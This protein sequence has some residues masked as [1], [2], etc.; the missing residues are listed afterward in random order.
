MVELTLPK[1]AHWSLGRQ[2]GPLM[3]ANAM[4][5]HVTFLTALISAAGGLVL[6]PSSLAT[7]YCTGPGVPVGCVG[8][9]LVRAT[10]PG[11]G[12]PGLGV[13]PGVGVT[14]GVGA[15]ARG[16]G[17]SPAAGPGAGPNAGGPV[18]RLGRR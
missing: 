8:R 7:P 12:A 2:N 4:E 5:R 1:I 14:P 15:G 13:S 9:P 11:V 3:Q 6:T 17:V 10:T 16:V 18:N